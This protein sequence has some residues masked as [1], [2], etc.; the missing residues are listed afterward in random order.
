LLTPGPDGH[1]VDIFDHQIKRAL[2]DAKALLG[3]AGAKPASKGEAQTV[4][5]LSVIKEACEALTSRERA[6]LLRWLSDAAGK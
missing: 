1:R 3:T 5:R 2:N 4:D 6:E